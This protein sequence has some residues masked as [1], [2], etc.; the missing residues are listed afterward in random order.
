MYR[1]QEKAASVT[2]PGWRG[3]PGKEAW[4]RAFSSL[5]GVRPQGCTVHTD[6]WDLRA[7][8]LSGAAAVGNQGK[9]GM[10]VENSLHEAVRALVLGGVETQRRAAARPRA[11]G[12]PGSG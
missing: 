2:S 3:S 4:V 9:P 1:R 12:W 8:R 5:A 10:D 6:S 11:R 7:P